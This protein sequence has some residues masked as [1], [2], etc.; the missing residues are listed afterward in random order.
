MGVEECEQHRALSGVVANGEIRPRRFGTTPAE[1]AAEHLGAGRDVSRAR[2]QDE[3]HFAIAAEDLV[4]L[5][6]C[7]HDR[8]GEKRNVTV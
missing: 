1:D 2:L 4:I 6:E 7:V 3:T 8:R 5:I